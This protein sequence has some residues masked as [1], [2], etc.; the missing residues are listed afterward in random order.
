MEAENKT[1]ILYIFIHLK[2]KSNDIELLCLKIKNCTIISP[3]ISNLLDFL[4]RNLLS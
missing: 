1:L 3:N 4:R 2:G